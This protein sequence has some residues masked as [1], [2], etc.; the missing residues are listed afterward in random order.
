MAH[1]GFTESGAKNLLSGVR[2][3]EKAG[4]VLP[5]VEQG[6]RL[7]VTALARRDA[8]RSSG[9]P[10]A[11]WAIG[12][13]QPHWAWARVYLLALL[14]VYCLRI[15]D[16]TLITWAGIS[17]QGEFTFFDYKRLGQGNFPSPKSGSQRPF[18]TWEEQ[19][20]CV[21]CRRWTPSMTR[22]WASGITSW[23]AR[24]LA[25]S[26]VA[27][28][29]AGTLTEKEQKKRCYCASWA[30]KRSRIRAV[31]NVSGADGRMSSERRT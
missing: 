26:Q 16:A 24:W 1:R 25:V 23:D 30:L 28:V 15:S 20:W 6:D 3:L 19:W 8:S 13:S 17:V 14:V 10:S 2:M 29:K 31:G 22:K 9:P 11:T 12:K 5:T 7:M 4:L 18:S 21:W 27:E